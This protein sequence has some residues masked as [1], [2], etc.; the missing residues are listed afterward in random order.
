MYISLILTINPTS[1]KSFI[2]W[3]GYVKF[4]NPLYL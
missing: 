2:E 4:T 3:K 1:L